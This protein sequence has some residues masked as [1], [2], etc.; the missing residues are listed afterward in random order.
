MPA[1]PQLAALQLDRLRFFRP[2]APD[3]PGEVGAILPAAVAN[4][5]GR[6]RAP[7]LASVPPRAKQLLD[8]LRPGAR[9][10][11]V[12]VR[13]SAQEEI[14]N[15]AAGP[16]GGESCLRERADNVDGEFAFGIG[17]RHE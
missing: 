9:G 10:N 7:D 12:I 13:S 17:G 3:L 8:L 11:V 1:E 5:L 6:V 15:A 4:P 14:A 16:Q 2:L